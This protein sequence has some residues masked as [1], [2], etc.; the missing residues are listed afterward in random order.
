MKEK[1]L[2]K[3]VPLVSTLF[4][5]I[6]EK[7]PGITGYD[8]LKKINEVIKIPI[9]IKSGTLYTQ[10]RRLESSGLVISEQEFSG[11][12]LRRYKITEKGKKE[13]LA[14]LEK[15]KTRIKYFLIPLIN[16]IENNEKIKNIRNEIESKLS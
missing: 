1:I 16:Y 14:K 11:R 13:L 2:I 12:K 7:N 6:I 5:A 3:K 9:E 8:I 15:I 4:L 10:L